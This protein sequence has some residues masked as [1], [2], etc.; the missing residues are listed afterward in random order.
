M[1]APRHAGAVELGGEP[2]REVVRTADVDVAVA[3]VGHELAQGAGVERNAVARADE[4]VQ[5]PAASPDLL[6]DLVAQ[7]EVL[8]RG[9][10]QHDD[11][12]GVLSAGPAAV[13][14]RCV[15]PTPCADEQQPVSLRRCRR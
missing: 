13:P 8:A 11:D 4:L 9:C 5:A 3:Q 15:M 12:V 10:A 6:G 14:D 1:L 7:D 2:A